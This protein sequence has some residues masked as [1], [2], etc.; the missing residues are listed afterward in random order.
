MNE[1]IEELTEEEASAFEEM[2]QS[3]L[4][5]ADIVSFTELRSASDLV[6]MYKESQLIIQ[7]EFQREFVWSNSD[8]TRFIDSMI[9]Q[10]PIPSMCLSLDYKQQTWQVI[11]GLQR[12]STIIKFLTDEDWKLS[13]LKDVDKRISGKCVKDF[14]EED[15]ELMK[16]RRVIENSSLPINVL[17][18][19]NSKKAHRD[20][21]F[22]IFHRLNTGGRAL[23]NQ[24][25]RNCVYYGSLNN[26]LNELNSN[27]KWLKVS[28]LKT[29]DGKRYRGQE[30]ILRLFA[31]A[32]NYES[33]NGRLA[34]FLNEYMD[35]NQNISK[36]KVAELNDNFIKLIFKLDETIGDE[37]R[38]KSLTLFESFLVGSWRNIDKLERLSKGEISNLFGMLSNFPEFSTEA[39]SEGLASKEKLILRMQAAERIFENV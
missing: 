23:T 4:P 12:I 33:Y 39:L 18:C 20:Y 36:E 25:I 28:R 21:I 3:E 17:R 32:E 30:M 26:L 11:D 16:M 10:L 1:L 22:E 35:Q 24:E 6:R 15:I 9:K 27:E 19:D 2:D 14:H 38:S 31:F 29:P 5:P 7:P 8:Q 34:R 13:R 37:A